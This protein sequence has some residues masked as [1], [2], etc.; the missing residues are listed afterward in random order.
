MR[1][2]SVSGRIG[3]IFILIATTCYG[4]WKYWE[5]TRTWEPLSMPICLSPGHLRSKE[6]R[7]N[8]E[9]TFIV[10]V[11]VERKIDSDQVRCWLGIE[12][13]ADTHSILHVKWVLSDAG[14]PVAR[15]NSDQIHYGEGGI[16]SLNREIGAFLVEKGDHYVLDL[17]VLDDGSLLNFG[18]PRLETEVSRQDEYEERDAGELI[19]VFAF[20]SSFSALHY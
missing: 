19:Y 15:G 3:A 13:C 7:I 6:F 5:E 2:L 8:V 12:I 16:E 17:D 20:P 4:A 9:A 18:N 14:K 1:R 10:Q 11:E